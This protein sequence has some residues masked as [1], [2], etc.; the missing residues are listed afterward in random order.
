MQH[1]EWNLF[2]ENKLFTDAAALV[3]STALACGR[4]HTERI[5]QAHIVSPTCK[6]LKI[7]FRKI[8]SERLRTST[9]SQPREISLADE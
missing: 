7:H 6:S 4:F 1:T 8:E 9:P 2:E 3:Q 5:K